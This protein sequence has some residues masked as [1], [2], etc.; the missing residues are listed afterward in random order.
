MSGGFRFQNSP[1]LIALKYIYLYASVAL[2]LEIFL[3]YFGFFLRCVK[4]YSTS[5]ASN[6]KLIYEKPRSLYCLLKFL[7]EKSI[8]NFVNSVTKMMG[9]MFHEGLTRMQ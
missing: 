8:K 6:K 5:R 7:L 3:S 2:I 9:K 4:C 1:G